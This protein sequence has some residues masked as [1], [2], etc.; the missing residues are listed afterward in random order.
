MTIREVA[1]LTGAEVL[2]GEESLDLEVTRAFAA[3]LMSDVLAMVQEEG[4][5][6]ITGTVVPQVVRVAEVMSM[7]AILFVRGKRPAPATVNYAAEAG[8]PLLAT[9]KIMFEACGILYSRGLLPAKRKALPRENG[10]RD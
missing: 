2:C 6:L 10:P 5:L 9:D 4:V 1:R 7:G 8:I 3:D